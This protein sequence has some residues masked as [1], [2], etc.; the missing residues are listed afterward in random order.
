MKSC[1]YCGKEYADNT[2]I[3][4]LDGKP[5]AEKNENPKRT[6][7]QP[8]VARNT[9]DAKL[10]SP[11]S[12]S[13]TYRV[14]SERSDLLF[15]QTED[16]SRSVLD[17]I[18]PFLGPTGNVITLLLW[19]FRKKK[20]KDRRQ[21]IEQKNPEDLLHENGKNFKL[22]PPEIR[23]AAIDPPGFIP[24]SGKAARLNL[25]VRHGEKLRFEF[26][27]AAEVNSAIRLLTPLL[28]ST[29]KINVEWNEEKYRF[30]R[31]KNALVHA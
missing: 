21:K 20:A 19:L 14:F 13:G 1:S 12:L 5:V 17:A 18:A 28:Y 4:P 31:K 27:S 15:I 6:P 29:L 16:H 8:A 23:E 3:C 11:L 24:I 30:Q 7:A 2:T 9:F 10:V 26:A 25:L 22:Y